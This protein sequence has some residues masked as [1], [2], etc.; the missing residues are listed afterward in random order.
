MQFNGTLS[1]NL[2]ELKFY[3]R[4]HGMRATMVLVSPAYMDSIYEEFKFKFP[5]S[6]F[7]EWLLNQWASVYMGVPALISHDPET[8]IT[9]LTDV[10]HLALQDGQLVRYHY[11]D[12]DGKRT[13]I[14]GETQ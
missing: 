1:E 10:Y 11:D 12:S 6:E 2:M 4:R 13:Y 14:I 8:Q 7:D 3:A 5:Y 9:L